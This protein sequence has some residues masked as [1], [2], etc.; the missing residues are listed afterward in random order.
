PSVCPYC[1]SASHTYPRAGTQQVERELAGLFP[2]A[3][4]AR[5]DLDTAASGG[6]APK[7]LEQFGRHE[8]D[9]LLGTQMGTKGLPFPKVSLVGILNTD[10]ALDR[11]DF[12][13]GE[14]TLQQILQVAGRAGRG[15]VP[16]SVYAQTWNP[17]SAV[18]QQ[19]KAHDYEAFAAVELGTR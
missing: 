15:D 9:I 13:A 11:P 4:V 10:M 2:Q 7:L 14:R 16:G 19:A 3:R 17:D 8:I 6:G 18:L 1:G 12:R 5:L